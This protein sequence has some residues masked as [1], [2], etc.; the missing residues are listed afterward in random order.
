MAKRRRKPRRSKRVYGDVVYQDD[1]W[2]VLAGELRPTASHAG[3]D[4]LF[5]YL[6]EKLP[7]ASLSKV[8]NHLKRLNVKRQGVYMAHDSFGVARYGG[9][10]NIFSR[11]RN[12]KRKY[13]RELVYYSFFI[14]ESKTH[15]R[16]IE[17]VILRAA[18]PQMLLNQRK[19]RD[20]IDPGAVGDY[21]P[22]TRF[23]RRKYARGTKRAVKFRRGRG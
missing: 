21:E 5:K 13:P 22:G 15:E 17:N 23:F 7:W 14:I 20:G 9:R 3:S 8:S 2:F 18:G 19:V 12:H 16:D 4:H 11:L 10:G 1:D 6:A